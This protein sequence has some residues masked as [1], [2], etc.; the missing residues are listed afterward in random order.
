[1]SGSPLSSPSESFFSWESLFW[2]VGAFRFRQGA[3]SARLSKRFESLLL[4]VDWIWIIGI[5][6]VLPFLLV[7]GLTRFTS[8]GA[9][10]FSAAGM[11]F[12]L[13]AAHYTA[14]LLLV[15]MLP[16]LMARLRL[17]KRTVSLSFKWGK[18]WIGWISVAA[19]LAHVV[20][21]AFAV[22]SGSSGMKVTVASLLIVSEIW[23]FATVLRTAFSSPTRVLMAGTIAR[24][25]IPT[26]A[27][28]LLLMVW[29]VPALI[30]AENYWFGQDQFT[31]LDPE[32]PG[33]TSF[34]YKVAVQL[35]KEIR[36]ILGYQP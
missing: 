1:M 7:I 27:T 19:I 9:R 33:M 14:L 2:G 34:E 10:D 16:V 35:Q 11:K 3:L 24:I 13:P 29:W 22:K 31:K 12:I 21:I 4:P 8:L 5:G 26:Y 23:L 17:R 15:L 6:V 20:L 36:E 25:L 32:F 28:A 30:A 18:S